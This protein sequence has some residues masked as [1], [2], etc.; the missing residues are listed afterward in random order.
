[1]PAEST[2]INLSR[3]LKLKNR[4]VHRLS[5][6]DTLITTY[7]STPE[8]NQEYEV[9]ELYETRAVWAA[10]LVELK[11][12]INAANQPIQKMIFALAESKSLVAMLNKI[13]TKHG[14]IAEGFSGV[15][16]NYVAQFRKTHVDREI[17]RAEREID[18]LQDALDRFNY[19]TLIAIDGALLDEEEPG[20][21]PI[22]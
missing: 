9:Q 21:W 7:N 5:Q 15:R 13:S 8:D 14:P 19:E 16:V 2:Q 22:E 4:L 6:L 17:G 20:P 11:T 1:M 10:R 3:A 18:R 12:Q